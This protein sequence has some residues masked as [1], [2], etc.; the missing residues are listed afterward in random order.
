MHSW[1][2]LGYPIA[3]DSFE[4]D[5]FVDLVSED[6]YWLLGILVTLVGSTTS[7]VG[8]T[9]IKVALRKRSGT[10]WNCLFDG[11]WLLGYFFIVLGNA[12]CFSVQGIANQT[13]LS[14]FCCWNVVV[15][16]VIAPLILGENVSRGGICGAVIIVIACGCMVVGA[17]KA[18]VQAATWKT[19][20]GG[21]R[22]TDFQVSAFSAATILI[23]LCVFGTLWQSGP[24]IV[25][26]AWSWAECTLAAA[27]FAS[28]GV[29][30]SKC[31][32]IVVASSL[33]SGNGLDFGWQGAVIIMAGLSMAFSEIKCMN[34]AL[35]L[36]DAVVVLPSY[37]SLAMV[38]QILTVGCYFSEIAHLTSLFW[39]GVVL[40]LVGVLT[41]ARAGDMEATRELLSSEKEVQAEGSR[42]A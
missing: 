11:T 31:F 23:C 8:Y 25:R 32:S 2:H 34:V 38:W 14:C 7:V 27:I 15:I 19:I 39:F 1:K 4:L 6:Y 17:G 35:S 28:Y 29:L 24:V 37:F 30:W 9:I 21:W 13:I 36:A 22:Q 10:D 16:F 33:K 5:G 26:T 41:L 12:L 3:H 18:P 20:Y 40:A 42:N